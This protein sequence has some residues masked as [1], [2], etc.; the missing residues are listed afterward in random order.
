M[1]CPVVYFPVLEIVF[2]AA[3][4]VSTKAGRLNQ[5]KF[6]V[7]LSLSLLGL[8][9]SKKPRHKGQIVTACTKYSEPL[10]S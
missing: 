6:Q 2:Y 5:Q 8:N 7:Y 4:E 10:I 3:L 9:K 1:P